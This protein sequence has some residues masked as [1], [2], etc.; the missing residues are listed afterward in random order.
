VNERHVDVMD[1]TGKV[2][3]TF[4]IRVGS[5]SAEP[6]AADY[7]KAALIAAKN[8]GLVTAAELPFLKARM[9]PVPPPKPR[10]HGR[11]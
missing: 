1:R 7:E 6:I 8:S 11:K 4:P 9:D 3:K 10:K 2:L 5:P